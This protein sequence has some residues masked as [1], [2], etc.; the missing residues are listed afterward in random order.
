MFLCPNYWPTLEKFHSEP[1]SKIPFYLISLVKMSNAEDWH[2]IMEIASFL[3]FVNSLTYNY[4]LGL[5]D[6]HCVTSSRYSPSKINSSGT[7]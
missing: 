7:V 2:E 6:S 5:K 3:I 4:E 1:T